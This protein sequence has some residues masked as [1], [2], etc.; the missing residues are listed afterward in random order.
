MLPSLVNKNIPCYYVSVAHSSTKAVIRGKRDG[1]YVFSGWLL[2]R[3]V[4]FSDVGIQTDFRTSLQTKGSLSLL[5]AHQ[6]RTEIMPA[7]SY[8]AYVSYNQAFLFGTC[9]FQPINQLTG[10]AGGLITHSV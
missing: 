2:A 1:N 7:Y 10:S 4:G 5:R 6:T 3:F 8:L 9:K